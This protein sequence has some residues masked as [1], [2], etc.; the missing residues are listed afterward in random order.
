[1]RSRTLMVL[2][3]MSSVGKSL[4][5]TGL[6]RL[7][8][9]RGWNVAP[10]KAQNMSNNAAV[11]AGG[12]IG[13]AQAVQA[14]AAGIEPHVDMNPVLLKPEADSR[15][16]VILRGQVWQTLHAQDYYQ[17]M[18]KVW[19]EVKD[20]LDRLRQEYDLVIMEGAGS[21]AELNLRSR[22][23]V[24]LNMARYAQAPCLLVGDI[25]RGG[26]FAQLLGTLALLEDEERKFIRALVVNKFRGDAQLFSDGVRILEKRS[27]LP[28]LG[29][30]PF[31]KNHYIAD[32]DAAGLDHSAP[33]NENGFD[34]AV[35]HLP[36]ISNFDD[37]DPLRFEPAVNLRFVNRV[38]M[39]GSPGAIILPG[40]KNTVDD[41][42]W[43]KKSG[44]AQ[45]IQQ[46][47]QKGIPVVGICGG[48][49]MLGKR[50][51][52]DY[53]IESSLAGAEGLDLLPIET[54]LDPRKTVSRS[55]VRIVGRSGFFN[56]IHDQ[57]LHGYEI[58]LGRSITE[59]PLFEIIQQEGQVVN[60]FDGASSE[61]GRIWGCHIHGLFENDDFRNAWL[62]SMGVKPNH[63]SFHDTRQAAYDQ[64]A[65]ILEN[66]L[67]MN[68]LDRIIAEG[69]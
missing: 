62:E 34:I 49:Q 5:V 57:E 37:F 41:L 19:E 3:S 53:K 25:D 23:I 66:E 44:F 15:S 43:L 33:M 27:G 9:R 14:F 32:E 45:S 48:Y 28:V 8:A 2:G 54:H 4:L 10:F 20:S 40:S 42:V 36:H 22:D 69:V 56:A 1:M 63:S 11:C 64:L 47:A 60:T 38:E 17:S 13:R 65:D 50:V 18:H 68:I 29:V 26:V 39:L 51:Q 24:N 67:D 46:L 16:Q 59:Q 61:N 7:F 55:E 52:D 6:C 35:I 58:H 12:E 30:V 31:I 21:P